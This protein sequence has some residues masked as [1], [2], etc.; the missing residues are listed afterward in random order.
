MFNEKS[1]LV[2]DYVL[3]INIGERTLE[4]VPN[5]SNLREMVALV[6]SKQN[7]GQ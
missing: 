5:V 7:G 4:K 6:L 3:L 1:Q 2:Q